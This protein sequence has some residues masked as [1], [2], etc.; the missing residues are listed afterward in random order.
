MKTSDEILLEKY[1]REGLNSQ[2]QIL[3]NSRMLDPSFN[4][5]FVLEK[6]LFECFNEN[7]WSFV[8]NTDQQT[9]EEYQQLFESDDIQRLKSTLK[10]GDFGKSKP[11]VQSINWKPIIYAVAAAIVLVISIFSFTGDTLQA[12][13]VYAS[14][15]DK[16]QLTYTVVRG[17]GDNVSLNNIQ[18]LFFQNKYKEVL[19]LINDQIANHDTDIPTLLIMKGIS[20]TELNKFEEAVIVYDQLINSDYLDSQKGYWYKGLLFLKKEETE[21]AVAILKK[22]K[23]K[24]LYNHDKAVEII[25]LLN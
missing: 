1:F 11:V 25:D 16:N 20:L 6:Q 14:Y 9:V 13:E 18:D 24:K 8:E 3:F 22:I 15:L 7:E 10:D 17:A 12:N 5:Q 23:D 4:D 2:E 19:P 21:N